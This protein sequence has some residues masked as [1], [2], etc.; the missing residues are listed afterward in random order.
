MAVISMPAGREYQPSQMV[1]GLS[2]PRTH[3]TSSMSQAVQEVATPGARHTVSMQ[4]PEATGSIR[5]G[6]EGL[7]YAINRAG[8]RL[9]LWDMRQGRS[10]PRGSINT[11]GVAVQ[12][13]AAQWAD[14]ITLTGCGAGKTLLSGDKLGV[15]LSGG[16][17]QLL[18][19]T[20]DTTANGS[21]AMTVPLH[22]QLRAAV[23]AG[24]AVTLI[25]PMALFVVPPGSAGLS[26][27][28]TGGAAGGIHAQANIDL[29]EVFS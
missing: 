2:D 11:S 27:S 9:Q 12:T 7:L 24:S 18:I 21:G 5:A 19:C 28:S 23:A 6:L 10:Q 13:S 4:W 20:A 26:F 25:R 1:W 8:N 22:T 29:I 14:A 16:L 17:A 15:V 3:S